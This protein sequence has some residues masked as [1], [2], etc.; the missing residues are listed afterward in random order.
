[1]RAVFFLALQGSFWL[2]SKQGSVEV[3]TNDAIDP[4]FVEYGGLCMDRHDQRRGIVGS[5]QMARMWIKR[6]YP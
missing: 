2:E 6:K 5:E 4:D 1:M 3:L